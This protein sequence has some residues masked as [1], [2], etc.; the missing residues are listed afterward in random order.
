ME[1]GIVFTSSPP[2]RSGIA[3]TGGVEGAQKVIIAYPHVAGASVFRSQGKSGIL[4]ITMP[5]EQQQP[6][7]STH[8]A[9]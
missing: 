3:C 4:L 5:Q 1:Q 8:S 2:P 6:P 7:F 9:W